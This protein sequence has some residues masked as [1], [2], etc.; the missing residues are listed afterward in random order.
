MNI[1][2]IIQKNT[3]L[4]EAS[5]Y[6]LVSLAEPMHGYGIMQKVKEVSN[7]RLQIGPG[8]LYGALAN[9]QSLGLIVGVDDRGDS[10]RRKIYNMTDIG[11]RVAE[12]ELMRLEEMT[13]YGRKLLG[14]GGKNERS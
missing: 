12:Y 10:D 5:F 4:T 14:H 1:E 2:E 13:I 7:G 8:T 3:P 9:L 11:R 6:I